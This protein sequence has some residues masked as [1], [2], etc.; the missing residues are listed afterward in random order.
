MTW[1]ERVGNEGW[2]EKTQE[3]FATWL[4]RYP[5]PLESDICG[6][7]EPPMCFLYDWSLDPAEHKDL[8]RCVVGR[9]VMPVPRN[10]MHKTKKTYW[11]K[12]E[13]TQAAGH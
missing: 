11:I 2:V 3:E 6:I 13:H 4:S 12:H 7:V 1:A 10:R 5:K 9:I 8:N